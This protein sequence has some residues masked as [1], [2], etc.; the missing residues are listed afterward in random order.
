MG[1]DVVADT[2]SATNGDTTLPSANAR[3]DSIGRCAPVVT[4]TQEYHCL[5]GQ[6]GGRRRMNMK[7]FTERME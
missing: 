7:E 1:S 3:N 5:R 6:D 2:V 4:G